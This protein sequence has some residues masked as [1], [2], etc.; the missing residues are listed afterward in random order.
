MPGWRSRSACTLLAALDDATGRLKMAVFREQEDAQG[1]FVLLKQ[2]VERWRRPL[3]LY[4]D[5]HS[6]FLQ[7]ATAGETLTQELAGQRRPTTQL[8][9]ALQELGISSIAFHLRPKA[10][11]NGSLGPCKIG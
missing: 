3:A 8:A 1:Y 11:W 4:H 10:G 9:W 2:L 7:T 6:M 5:R